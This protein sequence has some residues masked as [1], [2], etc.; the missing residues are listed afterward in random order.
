MGILDTFFLS[1]LDLESPEVT[2][3]PNR[4]GDIKIPGGIYT[5][6]KSG[7]IYGFYPPTG[8]LKDKDGKLI[9]NILHQYLP[10]NKYEDSKNWEK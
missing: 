5:N 8:V 6:K 10:T 4:T 1:N 3:G 2:G 9:K 7:N